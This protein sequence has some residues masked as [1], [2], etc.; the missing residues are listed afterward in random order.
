MPMPMRATCVKCG[1]IEVMHVWRV[2]GYYSTCC[3]VA[4][5]AP[6]SR[7][8]FQISNAGSRS[9]GGKASKLCSPLLKVRHV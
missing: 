7:D 9:R 5:Q 8:V 6:P 3:F 2:N 4:W 1:Q